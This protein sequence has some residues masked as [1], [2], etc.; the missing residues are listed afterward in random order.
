M[1]IADYELES[2]LEVQI[3]SHSTLDK[4]GKLIVYSDSWDGKNYFKHQLSPEETNKINL[5]TSK[6]L[7]SF[8][9][10]K[11]LNKNEY[12]AGSRR[13]ITFKVNGKIKSLCFIE[14][15]MTDEFKDFLK[16]LDKKIYSH[17]ESAIIIMPASD[18][19]DTKKEIIERGKVDNYLPQKAV[20]RQN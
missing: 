1:K 5:L 17:D 2:N 8:I 19:K 13:F 10:Q 9:K 4:E 14:P 20:I 18:F 11:Q 7:E 3:K 15:F 16:V 12:F 6:D